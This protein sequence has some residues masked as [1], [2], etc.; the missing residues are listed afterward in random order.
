MPNSRASRCRDHRTKPRDAAGVVKA[1]LHASMVP[2]P[3][4]LPARY[5][6]D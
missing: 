1:F 5:I 3:A 4:D 2:D 6:A